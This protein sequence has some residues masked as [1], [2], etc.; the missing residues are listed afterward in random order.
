MSQTTSRPKRKATINK[1]YNDSLESQL[2]YES[3]TS[4][5][6][7]TN[8]SATSTPKST[9]SNKRKKTNPLTK[10][11]QQVQESPFSQS[12]SDSPVSEIPY[13]WQPTP[14]QNDYFSNKLDLTDSYIDL[15]MQ[16]LYC[17]HQNATTTTTKRGKN[18]RPFTLSKGQCIYMISEP[19]GEPYYIG[20]IR[21]FTN[22]R[23]HKY[24]DTGS[25]S[26]D[27]GESIVPSKGYQ[28][29]V[30]WFFRPRD[31]S[32]ASSDSR[33]L[34]ATMDSD[35]CP[36][37]SFRGI[38]NVELKQDIEDNYS[39]QVTNKGRTQSKSQ[40][41]TGGLSPIESYVQT[42]NCFYFDRLYDRYMIRSYDVLSTKNLLQYAQ[43]ENSKSRNFL[44]ALN[45]RF[46]YI[47]CETHRTKSLI[48]S[49]KANTCNCDVCGLWCDGADS[50]NCVE[51]DKYFHMFCL[52]PPLQKKPSR[53]FSWSCAVCT[54]K[55]EI[56]YHQKKILMLSHDNKSSNQESLEEELSALGSLEAEVKDLSKNQIVETNNVNS[57]LPRYETMAKEF[58][59]NDANMTLEERRIKEEWCMRYLGMNAKLEEAVDL[60]DKSPY[61]RASTR[62]GTKHQAVYIPE[63]NGH[64]IVYYD[65]E[66][67]PR[68][69]QQPNNKSKSK[70]KQDEPRKLMLP[71]EYQDLDPKEYPCWLQPRPKGYI[72]RGV[73]DG[74]GVTCTL[75]WKSSEKDIAD[76]FK[77]LD[78]FVAKCA[79][80]AELLGLW[81]NS[82][83][84]CDAVAYSYMIHNGDVNKAFA[85]VQKLDKKKLKE[86]VFN[87]EE[88]KRFEAG[89]KEFGSELYYVQKKVKTQPLHQ[90]VRFYYLWKKTKN[91]RQIWGN[92]EGRTKKQPNPIKLEQSDKKPE[93]VIIDDL[94][95][96]DDDSSYE[97]GKIQDKRSQ[98]VCKHCETTSSIQWFRITGHDAKKPNEAGY[99]V[100]LC[101]R[102]AR[103]WRRYAVVW[104][105]PEEVLKKVSKSSGWRKG[106]DNELL[107]DANAILHYAD[108]SNSGISQEVKNIKPLDIDLK[109][110]PMA[111]KKIESK[112]KPNTSLPN[113]TPKAIKEEHPKSEKKEPKIQKQDVKPSQ[114]I[115]ELISKGLGASAR[116]I[117]FNQN[118][119]IPR[120]IK[121]PKKVSADEAATKLGPFINH[122]REVQLADV[123]TTLLP[124]QTPHLTSIELPFKPQER[125]CCVCREH[126]TARSSLSETLI[127]ANCGVNVHASCAGYS[128]PEKSKPIKGWLCEPCTNDMKPIHSAIYSCSLCLAHETNFELC[129]LGSPRVRPD[130]LKPTTDGRWCHL[131]CAIFNSEYA[132]F[133]KSK[134]AV[135]HSFLSLDDVTKVYLNNC[136]LECGICR[137]Y[138]G[139]LVRCDLCET[140]TYYHPTCAQDTP[141]YKL[142]FKLDNG[143]KSSQNVKV[144][145][146]VGKLRS[147]LV[148]PKHDQ[149]KDTILN[150][151]TLG[152]RVAGR[153]S[154]SKPIIQLFLEDIVKSNQPKSSGPHAK[155]LS[156]VEHRNLYFGTSSSAD[157]NLKSNGDKKMCLH[158]STD[159][160]PIWWPANAK[161]STQVL[162]QSCHHGGSDVSSSTKLLELSKPVNGELYAIRDR[163]DSIKNVYHSKPIS[164]TSLVTQ[165]ETTRSKISLGD[166]LL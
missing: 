90:V 33:L 1:S 148:C 62:V 50:I 20:R 131:L 53:G 29:L 164:E 4:S 157:K 7:S 153:D 26:N 103:L 49:F 110:E 130:F 64:P 117:L 140:P 97:N 105:S 161:D 43:V 124:L 92:F 28:F 12:H 59:D 15:K 149:S 38:V 44:I 66:K 163:N 102:C 159:M 107:N 21:G 75:L 99:V 52:D 133:K 121:V 88:V 24:N 82:P 119:S 152:R 151:R 101:F 150:F 68:K 145:E 72:E 6:L 147:I 63:C 31:V 17:P 143:V 127:C 113:S 56:E 57:V 60:D 115:D 116:N 61:P 11:Q 95:N 18:S 118:Y 98:F 83:N 106:V 160:S 139:A 36:L 25:M 77:Q 155:A 166:I 135:A 2:D 19:P 48:N 14:S 132:V 86:P 65:V 39:G 108:I 32:K 112:R 35:T 8:S 123:Y 69:K 120:S 45:K 158:C 54:K 94:A 79:P 129:L 80:V 122:Y 74:S 70:D 51:C 81:P 111:E 146:K 142:G 125:K 91:G 85:D 27:E 162:C 47:F 40:T 138:N 5:V 84:F 154:E 87:R 100:A 30:Q 165:V 37:P 42:P 141:N 96:P 22:N 10:K 55:H 89:V 41:P 71:K 3:S 128:L 46:Q 114:S 16:T 58:L 136:R 134:G 109:Q 13:N 23:H 76:N 104:E 67:S 78:A 156:Y 126:D 144:D 9:S 137:S 73:D 93:H 34:Y